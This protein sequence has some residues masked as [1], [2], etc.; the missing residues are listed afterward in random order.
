MG[1]TCNPKPMETWM[2][3]ANPLDEYH[4]ALIGQDTAARHSTYDDC[5]T[6]FPSAHRTYAG[7]LRR[8]RSQFELIAELSCKLM[9]NAHPADQI[10]TKHLSVFSCWSCIAAED[11]RASNKLTRVDRPGQFHSVL[12]RRADGKHGPPRGGRR[13]HGCC[14]LTGRGSVRFRA[15][16]IL[17]SLRAHASS[18]AAG[19][20]H[21][22]RA[23]ALAMCAARAGW[24]VALGGEVPR[25]GVNEAARIASLATLQAMVRA[26]M[27]EVGSDGIG[28]S[29]VAPGCITGEPGVG[30]GQCRMVRSAQAAPR[31][32]S[33]QLAM[34]RRTF[35]LQSLRL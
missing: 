16:S 7:I 35:P 25:S 20:T 17:R 24:V 15:R 26:I 21:F 5:E 6:R 11:A 19:A 23:F 8:S 18:E 28:V 32:P 1:P 10:A 27:R 29:S 33:R 30:A 13:R 12:R 22:C 31:R 14:Q 34:R 9:N 3:P 4:A 2:Q